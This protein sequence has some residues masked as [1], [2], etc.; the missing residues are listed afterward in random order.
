MA[1]ITGGILSS[2]LEHLN[3]N[4]VA[5]IVCGV[6]NYDPDIAS[7]ISLNGGSFEFNLVSPER[8]EDFTGGRMLSFLDDFYY[9]IHISPNPLEFGY[10]LNS[11]QTTVEVWNA[12]FVSKT[13]T[14]M[15]QINADEF[16]L[17]G[18]TAPFTLN[19]LG[20]TIY[21]ITAPIDGSPEFE[22][23]IFFDF[24]EAGD[25]T[26]LIITG[27]RIVLFT[28]PPKQPIS[29]SLEWLTDILTS[30]DGSEQ[31]ISVRRTPRQAFKF[32]VCLRDS[33][34]QAKLEALLH[35]WLKKS[36]GLPVWTE[37][38]LNTANI[39]A[40]GSS[41]TVDTTYADFRAASLAVIWKS[42]TDYEII[43]IATVAAGSLTLSSPLQKSFTG[44]KYIMPL[45]IV[46]V[47]A[48][49]SRK[50]APDGFS[51]A[52]FTFIVR[53]NV[54]L[55]GYSAAVTYKTLPVLTQAT[56]VNDMQTRINDG[57]IVIADYDT[58][59]FS[60]YSDSLFNVNTQ[61]HEFKNFTKQQAW[62]YRLFLH[63]LVGRLGSVYI[64]TFCQDLVHTETIGD[65]AVT[66]KIANIGL[67]NNMGIN[68][69]RTDLAFILPNGSMI[70]RELTGITEIDATEELVQIDS[71]LGQ[72]IDVG[73]CK[74][75]FL[76]KYR[77]SSDNIDIT[78][79]HKGF[80][81][82][83]TDFTR[84]KDTPTVPVGEFIELAAPAGGGGSPT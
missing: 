20:N 8:K 23:S 74:I 4:D 32:Q 6:F 51:F 52:D 19:A 7:D 14:A 28:W 62:N 55:S 78:W 77:I 56:Y 41:V 46:Q 67:A 5:G 31:R 68:A 80:N 1:T 49:V 71:A 34:E 27:T 15:N 37:W 61:S 17:S 43:K 44:N 54:L 2:G 35:K 9:R 60:L 57:D 11:V 45:R 53:D 42:E 40:G 30:K 21:T 48:P 58:G 16:V 59:I 25:Y 18:L 65:A 33:Q 38:V 81:A 26:T 69:L 75:C 82:S 47:N 29:E 64:P 22:S 76:D 39:T 36:F 73:G 24:A 84:V 3:P 83:S 66:F 70:L 13:C 72:E 79:T 63:H 12:Y 10:I 50:V